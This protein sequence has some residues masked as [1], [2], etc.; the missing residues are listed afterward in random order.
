M[1][2]LVVAVALVAIV[3]LTI[4]YLKNRRSEP[5]TRSALSE[6]KSEKDVVA[7]PPRQPVYFKRY[8]PDD[9]SRE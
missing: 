3:A 6:P 8:Y 2:W 7:G 5:S 4:L 1:I 9:S